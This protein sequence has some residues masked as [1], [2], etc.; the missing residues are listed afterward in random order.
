M[1]KDYLYIKY[2]IKNDFL[3]TDALKDICETFLNLHCNQEG[4]VL[5]SELINLIAESQKINIELT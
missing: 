2:L 4:M 1:G 3:N 5:Y